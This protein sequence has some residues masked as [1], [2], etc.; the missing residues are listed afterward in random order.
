MDAELQ[1]HQWAT[2]TSDLPGLLRH[3]GTVEA[4]MVNELALRRQQEE[5]RATDAARELTFSSEYPQAAQGIRTICE[6]QTDGELPPFYRA[7]I[8]LSKRDEHA[9]LLRACVRERSNQLDS[10]RGL[11]IITPEVV[12]VVRSFEYGTYD[13]DDLAAGL[14]PFLIRTV[15]DGDAA[16]QHQRVLQ[17][18]LV[19]SG[20]LAPTLDQMGQLAPFAPRMPGSLNELRSVYRALSVLLDVLLGVEHRVCVALRRFVRRWDLEVEADLL[21]LLGAEHTGVIRA[22]LPLCLRHT[23]LRLMR[24]F[25]EALQGGGDARPAV[26]DFEQLVTQIRFERSV[27]ALPALPSRYLVIP[28]NQGGGG[29]GTYPPPGAGG[30]TGGGPSGTTPP[31]GGSGNPGGGTPRMTPA[32]QLTNP[33]PDGEL[34]AALGAAQKSVRQLVGRT[35]EDTHPKDDAGGTAVCLAYA[36]TGKCFVT[37]KRAGTHRVLTNREKQRVLTW[38]AARA[39]GGTT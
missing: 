33:T 18:N 27:V 2:L 39:A 30:A 14:S 19:Q 1:H 5:A 23:Q 32:Q 3:H 20:H 22:T 13:V 10:T 4:M 11:P 35:N 12:T 31:P 7:F 9:A 16:L 34:V 26:P 6:V 25:T 8:R 29:P 36:L 37:C 21:S 38:V 24:Y 28:H 17:F 15:V